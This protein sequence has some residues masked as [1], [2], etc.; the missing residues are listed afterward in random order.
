MHIRRMLSLTAGLALALSA[1]NGGDNQVADTFDPDTATPA[2]DTAP[3]SVATGVAV[4]LTG[5]NIVALLDTA[6]TAAE[7]HARLALERGTGDLRT[8]AQ[9]AVARHRAAREELRRMATEQGI[10]RVL[11]D[12]DILAEQR[13]AAEALAQASGAQ[14]DSVY[15][16]RSIRTHEE[17]VDRVEDA[18]DEARN[19]EVA[20]FLRAQRQK[21]NVELQALKELRTGGRAR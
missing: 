14:F 6:Y 19:A 17:L 12:E 10:S 18:I 11:P 20:D 3:Q 15:I 21:L 13:A 1:C 2:V 16:D 4:L 5:E 8:F 9:Q 7:S